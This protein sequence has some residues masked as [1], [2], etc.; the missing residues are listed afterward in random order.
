MPNGPVRMPQV[1]TKMY[2]DGR[3]FYNALGHNAAVFEATE[4][5]ELM[6]S[7]DLNQLPVVSGGTLAGLISRA[8]ILQLLQTRAQLHL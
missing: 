4:A 8:H 3:V 1:W 5:L 7:Q 6:A 2:G